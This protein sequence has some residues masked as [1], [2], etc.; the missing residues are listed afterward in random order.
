[1]D[2]TEQAT[3]ATLDNKI[4]HGIKRQLGGPRLKD[5]ILCEHSEGEI[6]ALG[7]AI[8]EGLAAAEMGVPHELAW[9]DWEALSHSLLTR[10]EPNIQRGLIRQAIWVA[11][12]AWH[13]CEPL[14]AALDAA[15]ILP[16]ADHPNRWYEYRAAKNEQRKQRHKLVEEAADVPRRPS[17]A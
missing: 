1:M 10:Y 7:R 16:T 5:R 4:N 9:A 11:Y 8:H 6:L 3:R 14:I 15:E 17:A 13:R 12:G 2:A